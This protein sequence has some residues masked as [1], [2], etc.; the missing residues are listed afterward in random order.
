MYYWVLTNIYQWMLTEIILKFKNA[1]I[2]YMWN[3]GEVKANI[4][5]AIKIVITDR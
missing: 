3:Y 2:Y 5:W 1:K 4:L